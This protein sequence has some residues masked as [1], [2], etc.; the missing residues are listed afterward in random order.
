M[1]DY[2]ILDLQSVGKEWWNSISADS[3]DAAMQEAALGMQRYGSRD[4]KDGDR[5][6]VIEEGGG[7]PVEFRYQGNPMVRVER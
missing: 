4:L 7:H 6:W 2:I 1:S 3:P 5:F